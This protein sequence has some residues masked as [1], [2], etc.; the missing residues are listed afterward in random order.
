MKTSIQAAIVA[1]AILIL[2]QTAEA[3]PPGRGGGFSAMPHFSSARQFARPAP[4]GPSPGITASRPA[5]NTQRSQPAMRY[6]Q[7]RIVTGSHLPARTW[8]TNPNPSRPAT[9]TTTPP[10]TATT[11]PATRNAQTN[12]NRIGFAE[13]SRRYNHAWHD[14][15][16]WRSRYSNIVLVDGGYYYWDSGYWFPAWGYDPSYATYPY[17]GP[18][19]GFDGLNPDQVVAD[20]Q[21]QLQRDGYYNGP[22]NGILDQ[23]TQVAIANYQ[24]DNN[25]AVTSVVDA[26]TVQ[27]L[28]LS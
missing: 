18:I 19:Y 12:N 7:P 20:V 15:G 23:P 10:R 13:A 8:A 4:M 22:V 25:L 24:R 14:R 21:T 3:N 27:S 11:A 9:A 2:T 6:E 5:I 1:A 17:D 16:W 28:G 26:A